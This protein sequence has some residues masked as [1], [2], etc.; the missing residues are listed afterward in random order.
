[1]V[2]I[3]RYRLGINGI[4]IVR[5]RTG[6]DYRGTALFCIP[7]KNEVL[8]SKNTADA[9]RR[10]QKTGSGAHVPG[11]VACISGQTIKLIEKMIKFV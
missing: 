11:P 7:A 1:M 9:R 6:N 10:A 8:D 5:Y 4:L 3:S 2:A